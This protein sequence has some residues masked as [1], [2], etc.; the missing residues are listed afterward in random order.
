MTKK[1]KKTQIV[2]IEDEQT[3]LNL[4]EL[5]LKKNGYVVRKATDGKK[6]LALIRKF[7]PD[8]VLLDIVLPG[9]NGIDILKTLSQDRIVPNLPVIIISNS[10]QPVELGQ[11][12]KL[13]A[14][15]FLIKVNFN[16]EEVIEKVE[17]VLA[18]EKKRNGGKEK[19]ESPR[20]NSIRVLLVEDEQILADTLEKKFIQKKYTVLKAPNAAT[21]TTLLK[22]NPI[23]IILL[24]LV[25]PDINGFVFLEQL[26]QDPVF[27]SIPV[28]VISNLGQK[29]EIERGLAAGALEYIVKTNTSP[30]DIVQKVEDIHKTYINL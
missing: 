10:G 9:M 14:R 8:L 11:A 27:K 25:L 3:L 22:E 6:G 26:K 20:K 12:K 19:S 4:I 13:G 17:Q 24:D 29:E 7:K 23:D 1:Q 5:E 16:P 18:T 28:I 30:A 15:D 21:A 2:L